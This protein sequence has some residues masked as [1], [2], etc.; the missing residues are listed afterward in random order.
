MAVDLSVCGCFLCWLLLLS[1]RGQRERR[2]GGKDWRAR[3]TCSFLSCCCPCQRGLRPPGI[4]YSAFCD[5]ASGV[6]HRSC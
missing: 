1:L 4:G 6:P 5:A 3:A 2:I